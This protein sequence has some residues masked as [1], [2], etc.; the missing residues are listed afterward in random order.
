[1]TAGGDGRGDARRRLIGV[2]RP[3]RP[4]LEDSQPGSAGYDALADLVLKGGWLDWLRG[5]KT[6]RTVQCGVGCS[7]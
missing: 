6:P 5:A 3:P 7:R 2:A 4:E 1:M